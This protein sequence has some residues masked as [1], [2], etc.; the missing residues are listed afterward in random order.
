MALDIIPL[1]LRVHRSRGAGEKRLVGEEQFIFS[2][3]LI[4]YLTCVT[5][6]KSNDNEE[7]EK[8]FISCTKDGKVPC[9]YPTRP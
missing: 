7:V 6:N 8:D 4:R 3:Y 9:H 5:V 1:S 2:K